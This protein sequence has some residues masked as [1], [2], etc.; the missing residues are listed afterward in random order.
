MVAR[1][2]SRLRNRFYL[3]HVKTKTSGSG[4]RETGGGEGSFSS[5]KGWGLQMIHKVQK[6]E[7]FRTTER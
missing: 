4:I 3:L 6:L 2:D 1:F 7:Q 5:S